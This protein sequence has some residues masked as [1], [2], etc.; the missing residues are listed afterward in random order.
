MRAR[1]FEFGIS[2]KEDSNSDKPKPNS[3][4]KLQ[5]QLMTD[6]DTDFDG[7]S[8]ESD[9]ESDGSRRMK[10]QTLVHKA[11]I[12]SMKKQQKQQNLKHTEMMKT[13]NKKREQAL[14]LASKHK[15]KWKEQIS[16]LKTKKAQHAREM[17]ALQELL[18]SRE[19]VL[20]QVRGMEEAELERLELA[21][22]VE[23]QRRAREEA[24]AEMRN[25][26]LEE[27][28]DA[29]RCNVC[30]DDAKNCALGCGHQLCMACA[31][32]VSE[33]PTCREPVTLRT[34]VYS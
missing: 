14:N 2:S 31:S 34:R 20:E 9:E 5:L 4:P 11:E 10:Q 7:S 16:R 22:R 8:S 24:R 33:C 27:K 26:M 17:A 28:E 3:K 30:F 25:E 6:T 15:K 12:R 18:L 29:M 21:V 19:T 32:A 13:S 1:K 23:H